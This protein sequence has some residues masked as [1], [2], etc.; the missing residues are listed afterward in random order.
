MWH[1]KHHISTSPRV[2]KLRPPNSG[3]PRFFKATKHQ[4]AN[5]RVPGSVWPAPFC[6]ACCWWYPQRRLLALDPWIRI[7]PELV[8]QCLAP[9]VPCTNRA[10][11]WW[12]DTFLGGVRFCF[13][14]NQKEAI[15]VCF[16]LGPQ[17]ISRLRH[18][19]ETTLALQVQGIDEV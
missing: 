16:G 6:A 5:Q 15:D 10:K 12:N 7:G 18:A 3:S 9:K 8:G 19:D 17:D 14:S 13:G 2:P 1:V 4:W 11:H